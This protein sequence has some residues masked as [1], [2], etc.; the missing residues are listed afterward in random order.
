MCIRDRSTQSTWARQELIKPEQKD[1]KEVYVK[2]VLLKFIDGL[3]KEQDKNNILI[4][5]SQNLDRKQI[6][7]MK[8]SERMK[9]LYN[10]EEQS[11]NKIRQNK[12]PPPRKLT[13]MRQQ[14][15]LN[16]YDTINIT[17]HKLNFIQEKE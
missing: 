16:Q 10:H 1:R 6:E 8:A 12:T 2:S 5:N 3:V 9:L 7:Q 14:A 13:P 17:S 4:S 11:S 15:N